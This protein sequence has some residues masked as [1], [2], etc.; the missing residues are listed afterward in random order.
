MSQWSD[1]WFELRPS[2]AWPSRAMTLTRMPLH[3][4]NV[5]VVQYMWSNIWFEL[6]QH[7]PSRAMTLTRKPLHFVN[8]TVVRYMV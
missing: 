2:T 6:A 5:T 3:C 8:V 1:I 4:V 7:W